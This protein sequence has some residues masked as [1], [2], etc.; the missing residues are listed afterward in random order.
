MGRTGGSVQ[1]LQE[2]MN[3]SNCMNTVADETI[4]FKIFICLNVS[5]VWEVY[6]NILRLQDIEITE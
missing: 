6:D 3:Q 5:L 4:A 1:L 2:T